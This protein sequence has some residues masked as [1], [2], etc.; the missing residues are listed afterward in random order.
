MKRRVHGLLLAATIL[1]AAS[2]ASVRSPLALGPQRHELP[3]SDLVQ[4]FPP[5]SKAVPIPSRWWEAFGSDE[6]NQLMVQA[7]AGNL[8]VAAAWTRL[9]Q[10]RTS[11]AMA[12]A[13]GKLQLRGEAEAGTSR[14]HTRD[15]GTETSDSYSAGLVLSFELDV[16]GRID[17]AGRASTLGVLASEQDV[18]ATALALSGHV[19]RA[20]LQ[21]C[22]ARE[23]LAKVSAQ[24]ETS[25]QAL[26]LLEVR[27]RKAMSASVDV[28]QQQQLVASL[29]SAV[30][31]L[32]EAIAV[33]QIR[34][35]YL[36]GRPADAELPLRGEVLPTLPLMPAAGVP[37]D[38]LANRPDV[39]A[40]WNRL[41]AQ[42][43]SV[44]EARA[45]RLP[46][47]SLTGTS[48]L[49]SAKVEEL[50]DSWLSS[51][52]ASLA[53]PILDGGRRTAEVQRRRALA[54]E[55]FLS[56]RDTVLTALGEVVE[57]L[58]RERWRKEHLV[59]LQQE[60]DYAARTL[61][62][63]QRRYRGGIGDYLPVLTAL[64][65]LQRADRALVAA[66]SALLTNRV[67]LCQALGG[68]WTSDLTEAK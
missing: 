61:E 38:V 53:G 57:A 46:T 44:V 4:A 34:I 50:F 33:E 7:F 60:A 12:S 35:A 66:R 42:E 1:F 14:Q 54:D 64:S 63:A 67:S 40:A 5:D 32:R 16:W 13:D 49:H 22:A 55:R 36:L 23:E 41:Q 52:A 62:E 29:E 58:A 10:A 19:A 65:S 45:Q 28:L 11:T 20:W 48:S 3:E 56:Y 6:L 68:T 30:P 39:Q 9:R 18:H 8:S 2:C 51:L 21:L 17:A 47:L 24:I 31:S 15:V 37:A 27:R 25:R 59:R 26:G 43:W